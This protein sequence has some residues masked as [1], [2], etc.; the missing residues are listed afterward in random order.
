MITFS[1]VGIPAPKGSM[2]TIRCGKHARMINDSSETRPWQDAVSYAA[3]SAMGG[4]PPV[5]GPVWIVVDFY[6]PRPKSV[7]RA[8]RPYPITAPDDDKLLRAVYDAMTGIV[9]RDDCQCVGRCGGKW[10]ADDH[11]VG[12]EIRICEKIGEYAEELLRIAY[13]NTT[14]RSEY[15]GEILIP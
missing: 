8:K 4:R 15:L 6:L 9:Y 5:D 13:N 1:V 7:K 11:P 3:K 14:R 10:Y 12:V 2:R